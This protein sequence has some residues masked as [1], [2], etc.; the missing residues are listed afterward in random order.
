V[1]RDE[2][3]LRRFAVAIFKQA[4]KGNVAAF[5]EI[6]ER[7]EGRVANRVELSGES[8]G[9]VEVGINAQASLVE[10]L[11]RIY[12]LE[13]NQKTQPTRAEEAQR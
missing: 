7:V 13:S 11:C 10:E 1:L 8:G 4:L 6:C 12:G 5:K 3:A 2:K 9:S